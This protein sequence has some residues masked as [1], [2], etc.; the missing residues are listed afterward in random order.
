MSG[1]LLEVLTDNE[2]RANR[3]GAIAAL[4]IVAVVL[5]IVLVG[6]TGALYINRMW[7][8]FYLVA[9]VL[10]ILAIAGYARLRNYR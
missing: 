1:S 7:M 4:W 8:I 5:A 9:I 6:L 3:T 2:C 10:P